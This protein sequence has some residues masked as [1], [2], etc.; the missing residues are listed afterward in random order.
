MLIPKTIRWSQR[1]L[2]H[3]GVG[4]HSPTDEVKPGKCFRLF[5]KWSY[6][7]ELDDD[8]VPWCRKCCNLLMVGRWLGAGCGCCCR[9][10]RCDCGCGCGCSGW[11]QSQHGRIGACDVN[12][13]FF[14]YILSLWSTLHLP[15]TSKTENTAFQLKAPEIQRSN[16]GHVVSLGP[17]DQSIGFQN[18]RCVADDC[19]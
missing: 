7:H 2:H 12:T 8:N 16:L 3:L 15:K 18:E 13:S 1:I 9:R 11:V 10:C 6:E 5:T 14:R 17:K 19:I 4:K